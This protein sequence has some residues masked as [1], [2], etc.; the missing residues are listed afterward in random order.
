[1][2]ENAKKGLREIIVARWPEGAADYISAVIR[3]GLR[4]L[5]DNQ[6]YNIAVSGGSTPEKVFSSMSFKEEVNIDRI[7]IFWVDER[8]VAP[9]HPE[10]NYRMV[11]KSLI[12]NAAMSSDNIFRIMGEDEPERAAGEY[13]KILSSSLHSQ[14][15]FP[16]FDL[17]LLGIGGDGHTASIFPGQE[18]LFNSEMICAVTQN[19]VTR[20]N[21]IT[22]TGGV[23]NNA[24]EVIF[25]VSGKEKAE[26]VSQVVNGEY[27]GS[28]PAS[29]VAPLCGSL[30]WLLDSE[31]ARLIQINTKKHFGK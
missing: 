11:K 30:T 18:D 24:K 13:E 5:P 22:I 6:W 4:R 25:L 1:M 19:P 29:Y 28:F 27:P 12:D 16:R 2:K 14:N 8:C 20:Q 21:R 23:I 15:G 10:S 17:I 31:A 26:I 3:E 9:E 7:R